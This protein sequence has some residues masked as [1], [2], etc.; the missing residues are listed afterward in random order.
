MDS[1]VQPEKQKNFI[2]KAWEFL[3]HPVTCLTIGIIVTVIFFFASKAVVNHI[4]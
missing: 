3:K 4:I 2:L 1:Q